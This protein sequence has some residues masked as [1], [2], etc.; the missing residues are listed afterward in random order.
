M[1]WR[2][3]VADVD[4]AERR[5][6]A[7]LR[8]KLGPLAVVGEDGVLDVDALPLPVLHDRRVEAAVG[9]AAEEEGLLDA[10]VAAHRLDDGAGRDEAGD[11][12]ELAVAYDGL[13]HV[14][15]GERGECVG[16]DFGRAHEGEVFDEE[17]AQVPERDGRPLAARL[18][19][20][21][22]GEVEAGRQLV[23][24]RGRRRDGRVRLDA[25]N[26]QRGVEP[27]EAD[28]DRRDDGEAPGGHEHRPA[29]RL[30]GGVER[31]LQGRPVVGHAVADRAE[32][33]EVEGLCGGPDRKSTRLN[34][35]HK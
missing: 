27:L 29:A 32:V 30:H 33:R 6:V 7:G 23:A 3:G 20:E 15:D 12:V 16:G 5:A 10:E 25:A 26:L 28:R 11:A 8:V 24:G 4:P 9:R 2:R 1:T 19:Q 18:R 34:S 17:A 21:L 13:V 22:R 14:G 31:R 35:S